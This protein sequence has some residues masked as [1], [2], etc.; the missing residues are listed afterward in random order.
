MNKSIDL[1]IE[2]VI[3]IYFEQR[4]KIITI[5]GSIKYTSTNVLT[6]FHNNRLQ[7]EGEDRATDSEQEEELLNS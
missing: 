7:M 1:V 2:G 4:V 6:S 3:L 5:R